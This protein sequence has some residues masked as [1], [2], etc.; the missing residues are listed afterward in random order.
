[1]YINFYLGLPSLQL[2]SVFFL[3]FISVGSVQFSYTK[4]P[5]GLL[6]FEFVTNLSCSTWNAPKVLWIPEFSYELFKFVG[7]QEPDSTMT[8]LI[9]V[10]QH[11]FH[12]FKPVCLLYTAWKHQRSRGF[13]KLLEG[14]EMK[15]WPDVGQCDAYFSHLCYAMDVLICF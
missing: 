4:E 15:N 10:Y 7:L 5:I 8:I 9:N 2:M 13:Q 12:H 1:M 14:V 3:H 6:K 11:V